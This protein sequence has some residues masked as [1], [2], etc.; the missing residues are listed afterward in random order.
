MNNTADKLLERIDALLPKDDEGNFAAFTQ[1]ISVKEASERGFLTLEQAESWS[2]GED[3]PSGFDADGNALERSDIVHDFLAFLAEQMTEL[4][5]AKREQI[6]AF[7]T[8]LEGVVDDDVL[9]KLRKGKQEKTLHTRCE[10]CQPFVD[11]ASGSS[12]TLDESLA[13]NE[14]AFKQFAKLLAGRIA[15]LNDLVTVYCNHAPAFQTLMDNIARTDDL[16]DQI[17]YKLYGLT[18][19]EIAVVEGRGT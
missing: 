4:H 1:S 11:E 19:E 16:I 9:K 17:V 12:K 10:A 7:W 6:E 5:K 13:W 8:D 15:N 14:D 18:D 2:L 3:D